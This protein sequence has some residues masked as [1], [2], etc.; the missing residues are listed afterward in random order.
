MNTIVTQPY[1][2]PILLVTS[3]VL[4]GLALALFAASVVIL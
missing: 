2:Y 1:L 3:W 4:I